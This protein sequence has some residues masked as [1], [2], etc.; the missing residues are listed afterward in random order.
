MVNATIFPVFD[1]EMNEIVEYMAVRFMI[2]EDEIKKRNFQKNVITNIQK[3]KQKEIELKKKIKELERH[4]KFLN[5]SDV[6]SLQEALKDQRKKMSKI[7]KQISFYEEKI[8]YEQKE[9]EQLTQLVE[10]KREDLI[11]INKEMKELARKHQ[12]ELSQLRLKSIQQASEIQ[13]LT[14]ELKEK[15]HTITA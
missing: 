3:Q 13:R 6:V 8:K 9:N 2:T 4:L 15:K 12:D 10:Q 1:E 5:I 11:K 7:K 14:N